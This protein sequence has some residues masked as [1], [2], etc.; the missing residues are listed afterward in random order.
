MTMIINHDTRVFLFYLPYQFPQGGRSSNSG[1]IFKAYL[2]SAVVDNMFYNI[3]VIV[4]SVN[5]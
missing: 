5:R 1:H 2:I 3:H 4:Y